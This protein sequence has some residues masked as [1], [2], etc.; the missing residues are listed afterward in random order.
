MARR[1]TA[2]R[3]SRKGTATSKKAAI[4]VNFRE[5]DSPYGVR[6]ET[7]KLVADNLGLTVTE[8]IHAALVTYVREHVRTYEPIYEALTAEQHDEIDKLSPKG[9]MVEVL[10]SLY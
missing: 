8:V 6:R 4:L 10:E 5:K 9:R 3:A 7:V 1:K 2:K